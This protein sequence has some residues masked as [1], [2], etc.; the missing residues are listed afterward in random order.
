MTMT[1]PKCGQENIVIV[2]EDRVGSG[3]SI[4]HAH[5]GDGEDSTKHSASGDYVCQIIVFAIVVTASGE[6][7]VFLIVSV[8]GVKT[9][10][11][12][13]AGFICQ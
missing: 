12:T 9:I 7:L 10:G 13:F 8:F 5:A 11:L 3:Y 6:T 4:S 2:F 1:A